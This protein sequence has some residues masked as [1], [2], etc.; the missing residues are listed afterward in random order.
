VLT[1]GGGLGSRL[2]RRELETV[3]GPAQVTLRLAPSQLASRDP[4]EWYENADDRR[5]V[6]AFWI[7]LLIP[8]AVERPQTAG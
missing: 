5:F 4:A 8:S 2:Q 7:Q 6:L 1:P 3:F